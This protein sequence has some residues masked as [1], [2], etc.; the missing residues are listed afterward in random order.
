MLAMVTLEGQNYVTDSLGIPMVESI[1]KG[2][3]TSHVHLQ[4]L[5]DAI[6]DQV[7][8]NGQEFHL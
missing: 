2:L 3:H 7:L 4:E 6:G 8:E 1:R 5:G